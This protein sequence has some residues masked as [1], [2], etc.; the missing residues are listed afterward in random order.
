MAIATPPKIRVLVVDDSALMRQVLGSLLAQDPAI[1]V[2]GA[3]SDPYVA[4]DKIKRLNP[5]VLT[6]DVEMPRMDGLSFLEKLM[7]AH[8]MPVVMVSSLTEGGCA[9][10][11]RALELGAVDFVTKPKLDF[12]ER[13]PT[14]AREI[15]EKVK[16]AAVARVHQP[17]PPRAGPRAGPRPAGTAMLRTTDQVIAVGASTGGTEALREFML[18]LPADCPGVVVVQ[19]MPEKFTRAFADRLDGFCTV[20]VKE[21]EEGDRV[22][23]G[24]VLIAPGNYHMRLVREGATYRVR[25]N[26]EPP[27]NR[28]RPSVDVL[29]HS[30]A[31]TA[32]S[33]AIGVIM[34]GMGDD[35][36][37]GLLAMRTAGARTLA[38]DEATCVVFGM[39]RA[40]IE[41]GGAERVLPLG[42]LAEAALGIGLATGIRS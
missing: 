39:P 27:V 10:T 32:G 7:R 15:I 34:T 11:L 14:V 35:G 41:L 40:A 37:R 2:I 38:Q 5:D 29:L 24:H 3:A 4:R 33:N 16:N 13:M 28:H 1:E 36:A 20:R 19:H 18:A 12:R 9:T 22:L 25:L 17:A 6:L 42:C 31:E 23:T 21:A 26:S 30:C 8:P